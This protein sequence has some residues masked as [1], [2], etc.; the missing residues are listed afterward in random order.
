MILEDIQRALDA[1]SIPFNALGYRLFQF[2]GMDV[3]R[4][5]AFSMV[6][7]TWKES[8]EDFDPI[9]DVWKLPFDKTA[10]HFRGSQAYCCSFIEEVDGKCK[11]RFA[12]LPRTGAPEKADLLFSV[13]EYEKRCPFRF[14]DDG[15][16]DE[17]FSITSW[18]ELHGH[19]KESDR[20]DVAELSEEQIAAWVREPASLAAREAKLRI[21]HR[22]LSYKAGRLAQMEHSIVLYPVLATINH[23]NNYV[24]E[25][26]AEQ[27]KKERREGKPPAG[28]PHYI[29]LNR[30]T[31]RDRIAGVKPKGAQEESEE[32][33]RMNAPHERRAHWRVYKDARYTNLQGQRRWIRE[34]FIHKEWI[35]GPNRYK[36]VT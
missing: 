34:S 13:A 11:I 23:P 24:V 10:V 27:T 3:D 33:A 22:A 6:E 9:E 15:I 20:N 14:T 2:P 1:R 26:G 36:V 30:A 31:L 16:A 35:V 8:G 4:D 18:S 29:V 17:P 28:K 25:V 21:V 7:E 5:S 19:I 12:E 32:P